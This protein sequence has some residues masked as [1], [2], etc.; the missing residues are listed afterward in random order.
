MNQGL[1]VTNVRPDVGPGDWFRTVMGRVHCCRM[2]C[3]PGVEL[4]GNV[5][6][7]TYIG[8]VHDVKES[9]TFVA[10]LVPFLGLHSNTSATIPELVWITVHCAHNLQHDWNRPVAYAHK[11]ASDELNRGK[12]NGWMNCFN[13][14]YA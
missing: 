12:Q 3:L 14:T 6:P 10:I 4:I 2:Y 7:G 8:P 1:E 11:V 5:S 9:D 13:N